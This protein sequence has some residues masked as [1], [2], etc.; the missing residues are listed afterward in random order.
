MSTDPLND[1]EPEVVNQKPRQFQLIHLLGM[2]TSLGVLSAIF[3]PAIRALSSKHATIALL[4]LGSQL[5]V[6]TGLLFFG[7]YL[8]RKSLQGSG[9]RLGQSHTVSSW[10]QTLI[11]IVVIGSL[12]FVCLAVVLLSLRKTFGPTEGFIFQL[13]A[14]SILLL[15]FSVPFLL[16]IF[17][18]RHLGVVEFF[19]HGIAMSPFKLT[20]WELVDVQQHE[21]KQ[22][23][24][25]LTVTTK[26]KYTRNLT[27]PAL[28]SPALRNYL[29]KHHGEEQVDESTGEVTS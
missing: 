13:I 18:R 14:P 16:H 20:P 12:Q 26:G 5:A 29:L 7:N 21:T 1:P 11:N 9:A 25:Q 24:I 28:V 19:E 23:G 4:V 8:R 10:F 27:V 6:I 15:A 2:I 17:W 22:N 3:A